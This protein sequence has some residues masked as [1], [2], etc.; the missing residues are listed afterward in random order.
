MPKILVNYKY[1]KK[2]DLYKVIKNDVVFADMPVAVMDMGAEYD[3]ILIVPINNVSTVVDK[4]EY[5][6]V[7]KKVYL[8]V[9]GE[10]VFEAPDGTPF[11]LPK[12][13][14]ISKLR[15]INNQLVLV[16]EQENKEEQKLN[17][18]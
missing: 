7:N 12:Q 9:D 3:D 18:V 16:D 4:H 13:T 15:F 2:L 10:K 14:D 6:S 17:E 11:Y 5:L 8:K 1:N